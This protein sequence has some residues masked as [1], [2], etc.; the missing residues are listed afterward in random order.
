ML[1]GKICIN[2]AFV[3][4]VLTIFVVGFFFFFS[5]WKRIIARKW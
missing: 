1:D 2:E 4:P 5:L 3:L